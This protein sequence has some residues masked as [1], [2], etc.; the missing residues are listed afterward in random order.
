[1]FLAFLF[2]MAVACFNKLSFSTQTAWPVSY[3]HLEHNGIVTMNEFDSIKRCNF[4]ITSK[5]QFCDLFKAESSDFDDEFFKEILFVKMSSRKSW[6]S[7]KHNIY[8]LFLFVRKEVK[9]F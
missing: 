2:I 1:M 9:S 8:L 3:T 4:L 6:R 5:E 7:K